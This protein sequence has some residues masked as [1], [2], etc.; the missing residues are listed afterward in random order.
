MKCWNGKHMSIWSGED[1]LGSVLFTRPPLSS[2]LTATER[3]NEQPA[4]NSQ[5]IVLPGKTADFK[6]MKNPYYLIWGWMHSLF[7]NRKCFEKPYLIVALLFLGTQIIGPKCSTQ[8]LVIPDPCLAQVIFRMVISSNVSFTFI[9]FSK[10]IPR[11]IGWDIRKMERS[12]LSPRRIKLNKQCREAAE[13]KK[14]QEMGTCG[15]QGQGQHLL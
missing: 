8:M 12:V 6:S 7:K 2:N 11:K 3:L 4:I 1:R 10:W 9:V 15:E 14:S 13:S 5:I